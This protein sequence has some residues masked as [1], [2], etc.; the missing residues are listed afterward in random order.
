MNIFNSLGSNYNSNFALKALIADNKN[1][2]SSDLADYLENKYKGKAILLYKGREAL[3][4]GLKS[5]ELPPGSFVAI[6]GFTCFAVYQAIKNAGLDVEYLDIEKGELNFSPE[7]LEIHLKKN[8]KIKV[9]IIQNTLGYPCKIEEISK[10]C[11]KN[12]LVLIEDLA[13]SIGARYRNGLEAGRVGDMVILSFSQDK[14]IDGI[15]GGALISQKDSSVHLRGVRTKKQLIDRFYP[16]FTYLIR[17]TYP[18]GLGKV[19]HFF[20]KRF[21]LLSGPMDKIDDSLHKLPNWY[22]DLINSGFKKL[23][24]NLIHRKKIATIYAQL[25]TPKALSPSIASAINLSSNLRFPIFVNNRDNLIKYLKKF[26][27]CVSDIWY[28]SPI[29]PKKYLTLTD[30]H[31][32]CPNAE[33]AASEILNLP[34]HINISEENAEEISN[35]INQWYK[36][37]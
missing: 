35:L 17:N 23:E 31:N 11:K 36:Q 1:N 24:G 33:L 37:Q 26:G 12:G 19:F 20:L 22:Y 14:I 25:I 5:L 13:H 15:S 34:T 7:E 6:N 29:A 28:D 18:I 27:V 4:L 3:E 32:Q 16:S 10:I 2:Y 30:Y 21:N 8:P 9:V